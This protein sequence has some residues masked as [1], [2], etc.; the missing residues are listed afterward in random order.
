MMN[1]LQRATVSL[2]LG[3][4]FLASGCT[5]DQSD[6]VSWMRV[7]REQAPK[8]R[9]RIAEPKKFEPFRYEHVGTG[10]PFASAK[11][12]AAFERASPK[13][14]GIVPDTKRVREELEGYPLDSL[15][16]VGHLQSGK[17]AVALVQSVV[18]VHKV[19]VGNYLGQNF[20][21]IT[22]VSETEV[23]VKELVQ[24][25]A[26]EWAEREVVLQLQDSKETK[27]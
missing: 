18:G 1:V 22:R 4:S 14:S 20:G 19:K 6:L 5:N 12:L 10:D 3:V 2:I 23:K 24:D 9:P 17:T 11:L 13:S 26:G 16:L 21:L 7:E 8:P 15:R 27:K 25:A